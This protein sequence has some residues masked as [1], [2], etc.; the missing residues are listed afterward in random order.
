MNS[1]APSRIQATFP[2]FL[3]TPLHKI[4]SSFHQRKHAH[5]TKFGIQNICITRY[6]GRYLNAAH[7]IPHFL[8]QIPHFSAL[9]TISRLFPHYW[10]FPAYSRIFPRLL[11]LIIKTVYTVFKLLV[12]NSCYIY[13]FRN[14][15]SRKML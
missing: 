15:S 2:E 4:L 3:K 13:H 12:S 14:A 5:D 10:A 6:Q 11:C 7:A 8:L 1:S 9:F